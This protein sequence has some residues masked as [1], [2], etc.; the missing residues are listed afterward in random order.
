MKKIS[1]T[2]DPK[3]VNRLFLSGEPKDVKKICLT[4]EPKDGEGIIKTEEPIDNAKDDKTSQISPI[5]S[6]PARGD[7]AIGLAKLMSL[8][9]QKSPAVFE[10][11]KA[12]NSQMNGVDSNVLV[13]EQ[14]IM[15]LKLLPLNELP[16]KETTIQFKV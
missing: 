4:E 5:I 12:D 7:G 13:P 9:N 14:K 8:G 15:K 10:R 3:T 11:K 16:V 1:S 6:S 2:E